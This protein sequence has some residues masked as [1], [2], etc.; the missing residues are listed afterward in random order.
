MY[1]IVTY[2]VNRT[3]TANLNVFREF[4]Y[5]YSVPVGCM[6]TESINLML[7]DVFDCAGCVEVLLFVPLRGQEGGGT[8]RPPRHPHLVLLLITIN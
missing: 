1:I 6:T 8:D 3:G 2:L 5:R 7:K 4:N